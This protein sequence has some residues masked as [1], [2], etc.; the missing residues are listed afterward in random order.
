MKRPLA[1]W[2]VAASLVVFTAL[3]AMLLSC[4]SGTEPATTKITSK[5]SRRPARGAYTVLRD[6]SDGA[7]Q[8]FYVEL[9]GKLPMPA[10]EKVTSEIR[11]E[12]GGKRPR[13]II[14][15]SLP[16]RRCPQDAWAFADFDPDLRLER[17]GW[18]IEEEKAIVEA[19]VPKHTKLVGVWIDD[20]INPARYTIYHLGEACF[21]ETLDDAR[22]EGRVDQ[23]VEL[24]PG[25]LFQKKQSKR[26]FYSVQDDGDLELRDEDGI[27]LAGTK[28]R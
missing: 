7:K 15:F 14:W 3:I 2:L 24:S 8:V 20:R 10:L 13:T 5:P 17:R 22:V 9:V 4:S 16:K 26:E 25:S 28:V 12:F 6:T 21:L 19:P 11:R 1:P 23:L 27:V 18:T